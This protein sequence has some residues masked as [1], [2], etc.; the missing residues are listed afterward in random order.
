[1]VKVTRSP[2]LT[3]ISTGFT[4]AAV[5]RTSGGPDGPGVGDGDAPVEEPDSLPQAPAA[6]ATRPIVTMAEKAFRLE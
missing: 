2:T 1:L 6:A 4:P 5:I 3:L